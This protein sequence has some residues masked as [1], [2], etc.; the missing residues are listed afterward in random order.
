[1]VPTQLP[2]RLTA[3]DGSAAGPRRR[4]RPQ[5]RL[6]ARAVLP[7][8]RAG[9]PRPGPGLRL[10]R[11][12]SSRASTPATPTSLVRACSAPDQPA[13][14]RPARRCA[15]PRA[16]PR[17][18]EAA[19]APAPGAPAALAPGWRGCATPR[20][21]T[22]RRS[23]PLRRVQRVLRTGARPVD[24]LHLRL[25]PDGGRDAGGG[26][27]RQVRPG[28]PQARAR[29]RHA[30]AR[31][32]LRLGRHG[33]PRR[34]GVR[35][36]RARRHALEGAGRPGPSRRSSATASRSGRGPAPGLPRRHRDRL[37]RDQLDRPDRAHR[38]PEV[39]GVLRL[40]AG[41]APRRR[42]AAQPLHHPA[43]EQAPRRGRVHRPLR[44]PRRRAHRLR[45]DHHRHPGRRAWR[46]ATRRTCASTT[47]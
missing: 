23:A 4:H 24:D 43:V 14:R 46:C 47:P 2:F 13:G 21:V 35:R 3:Y 6:P 1:M 8:D 20:T 44:L 9:R 45:P 38:P 27:G 36:H 26:P 7:A 5:P 25:L 11:P 18:P 28:R 15:A 30:A 12:R 10:R 29:A 34:A 41:P 17:A 33:P 37:R 39:P 32:R 31:R 42:P 19:A 16:R 40:P 22:R